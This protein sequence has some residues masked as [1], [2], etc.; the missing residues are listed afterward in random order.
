MT[1]KS[2]PQWDSDGYGIEIQLLDG[3][4][5]EDIYDDGLHL[6]VRSNL[7]RIWKSTETIKTSMKHLDMKEITMDIEN[8]DMYECL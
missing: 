4:D 1:E 6:Y 7:N 5:I 8:G 3:E 2:K